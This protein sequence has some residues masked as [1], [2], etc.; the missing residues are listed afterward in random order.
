M[1]RLSGFGMRALLT[2]AHAIHE[3]AQHREETEAED[4]DPNVPHLWEGEIILF[5]APTLKLGDSRMWGRGA[6]AQ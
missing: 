2:D 6:A 3:R 1:S 5:Q 4:D